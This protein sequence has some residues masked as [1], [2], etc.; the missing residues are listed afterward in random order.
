[1]RKISSLLL[2]LI[3][4]FIGIMPN[5]NQALAAAALIPAA[6]KQPIAVRN[7]S[8][9][10]IDPQTNRFFLKAGD[11]GLL[12]V[13][14][15][16]GGYVLCHRDSILMTESGGSGKTTQAAF[17]TSL[18]PQSVKDYIP[19]FVY[20]VGASDASG[21]LTL[22]QGPELC[23]T[24][25]KLDNSWHS[26]PNYRTYFSDGTSMDNVTYFKSLLK[27]EVY[28]DND[29]PVITFGQ[30]SNSSYLRNHAVTITTKDLPAE[31][32]VTTYYKW[33]QEAATP[34]PGD[35]NTVIASGTAAPDPEGNG[36]Y[37]LHARAVDI[38]GHETISTAGPFNY[39]H[40]PP[41][42]TFGQAY[43]YIFKKSH[44]VTVTA[45]D[46]PS[47]GNIALFYA[48][49][50]SSLAPPAAEITTSMISGA[51][52]LDPAGSGVF[53]LH[54]KAIDAAG[55]VTVQ[56][57]GRFFFDNDPPVLNLTPLS[58]KAK[59]SH[60]I[61]YQMYDNLSSTKLDYAWLKDGAAYSTGTATASSG[62]LQV[63]NSLEGSYKLKATAADDSGNTKTI[64]T[65]AYI[66]DKSPPVVTFSELGNN[67]P[68]KSR[69]VKVTLQEARGGLAQ[70][71]YIW[72]NSVTVP[73]SSTAGW[74]PFADGGGTATTQS[75]TLT[76]PAGANT[77][78]YLH[79]KTA[80]SAGNVG[81]GTTTQG[82]V[83][84]NTKPTAVFSKASTSSYSHSVTTS[85]TL[86]DNVTTALGQYV[87]KYLV[88]DQATTDGNDADWSTSTSGAFTITGKSGTYYIHA[89]VY[90]QAGNWQLVRGGPYLLDSV[91]PEGTIHIPAE[92]TNLKAVPVELT[93]T[94]A[95]GPIDM[96]FSVNG[97]ST[98]SSWEPFAAAKTVTI[99]EMEGTR[100]ISVQY[101]DAAGN[102]SP[103]YSDTVIYDLTKPAAVKITY[104]TAQLTNQSVTATLQASDNITAAGDID[105]LN[106]TGFSYEF[107]ANGTYTFVF[108]DKAGNE[109]TAVA[110]VTWIDKIKPQVQ[111]SSE[112]V[113]DKRKTASSVITATDNVSGANEMTYAYAW[114][115]SAN[116]E[117]ETWTAL[118]SNRQAD[119]SGANGIW[120]LWAKVKDKAGNETIRHT[121]SLFQLDNTA[122]VGTVAYSPPG[123]TAGNVKA[124][125][126][127][128]ESVRV[129][130]PVSGSREYVF[131]DN[132]TFEFEFADDAGNVGRA[133][134][135]VTGIDRSL[136]Y[137]EVTVTPEDWTNGPVRVT[138]D[139]SGN[140][141][142]SL[143]GIVVPEDAIPVSQTVQKVVY[144]FVSN[145]SLR[146]TLLDT[147]TMLTSEDEVIVD[148]I[149][150]T[151]PTGEL[152]YS[153][154]SSTNED[155][156]VTLVT[157]DENHGIVSVVGDRAFTFTDNGT[158]TFVFADEAGNVSQLTAVVDYIDKTPPVPVVTYSATSWTKE[159]VKATLTFTGEDAP[160]KITN[161]GGSSQYT[162]KEN[163]SFVFYYRDAAGNEGEVTAQ[164]TYIDRTPPI[165]TVTYSEAGWTNRD[166]IA[167]L[168]P[169]DDSG[170]LPTI[171][172]NSGST[173]FTF[174]QNGTFTFVM[175]DA[176]GNRREVNAAFDRIDKT[177]P[178]ATVQYSTPMSAKTN[179]DVR[180]TVEANEPIVAINNNGSISRDFAANGSYGFRVAD[181]AGNEATVTA[182]VYN[183]DRTPPVLTLSYSTAAP[184][185]DDVIVTV[186]GSEA[187][188]VLNNNRAKQYVFKENGTFKFVVQDLAGNIAEA[189]ATVAN[190]TKATAKVTYTFSETQP[191]RN[192]VTVTFNA[193]R[194][195]TYAGITGNTV[196]FT[197]N[198]TRWIEATDQLNN[199]YVLRIDVNNIDRETPK[200]TFQK[201]DQ[202]LLAVGEAVNPGAD[203]QVSDNLDGSLN[204]KLTVTHAIDT[205]TPGEYDVTYS[206]TDRAGNVARIVRKAIVIAP[207]A[208]SVFV[209]SKQLQETEAV[210]YG[211]AIQ[212]QLFGQQGTTV[213]K[214]A[215]GFKNKGD[216]KALGQELTS[217][218][219][220]VKEY[221]LYTFYMQ[222][223]ERQTKL[224]HVYI[225][226]VKA[227]E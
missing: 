26:F 1:M 160:V 199:Q 50:P 209:N 174:V 28:I 76:S 63:P 200:L 227:S 37:Y 177:P 187:V 92:Q 21:R 19:D 217:G 13:E 79:L 214:W 35:I 57:T 171:V 5:P 99:P 190:I 150:V 59:T 196:T 224:V 135:V 151:P 123:R 149:D 12:R 191:T 124:V 148:H 176:A 202:L 53:Y 4:S 72:S 172:N 77:T 184:T 38:V 91:A 136:P 10:A 14:F 75:A 137:A 195:L 90:D 73:P 115:T 120:Y 2:A 84:D 105:V 113:S 47:N 27:E 206:V 71:S 130:K 161:N 212:L 44:A 93:A 183:I 23:Y 211:E 98:W 169:Q 216:F 142:L 88:S 78:M 43:N 218:S 155:V 86:S 85:L 121:N 112:G 49:T 180:A 188:Q 128:N 22:K 118:P 9:S 167:T 100:T 97:G 95:H 164:V 33:T 125:L 18:D 11:L 46:T 173:A 134:A 143:R 74:M 207:T 40:E 55:N 197:E 25:G 34:A 101:R 102:I 117:P 225:L 81:Y 144:D 185:K 56:S 133:T 140:S 226:P 80:D 178:V 70:S 141:A 220:P 61:S 52:A 51:P 116:T 83:L 16:S 109:N 162:F 29:A 31:G 17:R 186:S 122:P 24:N 152:I 208:F 215:R 146:Y 219:L 103:A 138:V 201:G 145:G 213:V 60:T 87:I 153:T 139:A 189:V 3:L 166:V 110:T 7:M 8:F 205:R 193:D 62:T 58:G 108:R 210:V 154:E 41:T 182:N 168:T 69:Q 204:D 89:K 223:Q 165:G 114:S 20:R 32:K 157:Y 96:S 39:D 203:V 48:W 159:D 104:S 30:A 198:G 127:T 158:H 42:I 36:A 147:A 64:E 66:I 106:L 179:A 54:A 222:D 45:A 126:S 67:T 170:Q 132:G 107:Q 163:G 156:T 192:N 15:E 181:R 194:P 65:L 111:F 129:T 131:T 221:G 94:D 119:L 68:A 82:F 175:E 6:M